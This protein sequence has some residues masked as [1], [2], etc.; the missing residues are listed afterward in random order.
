HLRVQ[1]AQRES[2]SYWQLAKKPSSIHISV[3]G[4]KRRIAH[5]PSPC[6]AAGAKRTLLDSSSQLLKMHM[7]SGMASKTT[8]TIPPKCMAHSPSL[9]SLK[10]PFIPKDF[11]GEI[12]MVICQLYLNLFIEECLKFCSSNQEATK[13]ALGE[14]VANDC[15]PSRNIH[16]NMAVNTR[17][18]LQGLVPSTVPG[19][20]K[21]SGQRVVSH[22]VVLRDKLAT[23]TSFSLNCLSNT[24]VEDLKKATLYP[25]LKKCLL[26]KDQLKENGYPFLP[27]QPGGTVI[28]TAEEELPKDS[29]CRVCCCCGT[30]SL[31][32]PSCAPQAAECA[33]TGGWETQ[34]MCSSATIGSTGCQVSKQHLQ[35]GRK[36]NLEGF[37]KTFD[38]ELPADVHPRVYALD[39]EMSYATYGLELACITVVNTDMQAFIKLDNEIVDDNTRFSAVTE[40]DLANISNSLQYLQDVQTILLSMFNADT[41]LIGHSLETRNLLALRFIHSTVVDTSVLFPHL[42]G[43]PYKRSLGK[44]MTDY[45][46]Q[47]IQDN[48]DGHSS[49]DA[50]AGM[51]LVIWNI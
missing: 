19:L 20:R 25:H 37:M 28:F 29:S 1:Q 8:S 14:K 23:K 4:E 30:E 16:L 11:R 27:K 40:A 46:R 18:K 48:M 15:R 5:T 49:S 41:I 24:D 21:T 51:H 10:Q 13:K 34:Y 9:Q 12:P 38:K 35:D 32:C 7:L 47:I 22:E 2:A 3:P 39:S 33:G 44:L 17:K 31:V 43:L 36:E 45:L 26:T 42:L 6:L 50:R